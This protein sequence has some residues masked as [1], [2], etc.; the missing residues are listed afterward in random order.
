MSI[1]TSNEEIKRLIPLVQEQYNN[2]KNQDLLDKNWMKVD[3]EPYE[4]K[5]GYSRQGRQMIVRNIGEQ[6][7][8]NP[9]LWTV[10]Y[11]D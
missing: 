2:M 11:F 5:Y 7:D 3:N 6:H 9:I 10:S 1:H 8:Y 4:F